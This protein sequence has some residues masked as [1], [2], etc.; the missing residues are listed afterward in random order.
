MGAHH[1]HHDVPAARNQEAKILEGD[2]KNPDVKI[3]FGDFAEAWFKDRDYAATT[4]ERN[5]VVLNR[6][7]LP[8]FGA[9]P[10]R[11]ITTPQVRPRERL[12]PRSPDSHRLTWAL[13]MSRDWWARTVSNRRHL[14]CKFDRCAMRRAGMGLSGRSRIRLHPPPCAIVRCR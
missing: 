12:R 2:W 4:R 13:L 9:V 6:F 3:A 5:A 8:T 1:A 10:L 11:E 14:P 7:I